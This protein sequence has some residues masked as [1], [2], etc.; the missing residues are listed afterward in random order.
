MEVEITS[1]FD[2][3]QLA[4]FLEKLNHKKQTYIGYCGEVKEEIYETLMHDFSDLDI[5]KSFIV[6]YNNAELVGAIGLDIDVESKSAEVWG[7][8]ITLENEQLELAE[9][10]WDKVTSLSNV[11]INTFSFFIHKENTFARQFAMDRNAIEKGNHAILKAFRSE[12]EKVDVHQ[13]VPYTTL[14]NDAFTNLHNLNFPDTYYC[15]SDILQ[16]L[17]EQNQL[18]VMAHNDGK[19]KGYVYVEANP[20]HK[21]GTIEYIAVSEDYRKQGIGTK[22]I[23]AA[24]VH[25]FSFQEIKEISLTVAKN[26]EKAINLYKAAGFQEIHELV[27]YNVNTKK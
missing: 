19:L 11:D 20:E 17:N 27:Y 4:H 15:A 3:K 2:V 5:S 21:E 13:I 12:L 24:L 16:R 23:Q 18:F 6:A 22:L 8:F 1:T 14:H 25:L 7:P 26:N 9:A 10:L